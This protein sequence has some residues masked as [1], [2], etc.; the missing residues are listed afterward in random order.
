MNRM[1]RV[2]IGLIAV[3]LLLLFFGGV[4]VRLYTDWVWF[5]EDVGYLPVFLRV[6]GLKWSLFLLFGGSFILFA[7]VNLWLA[8][9]VVRAAE[10]PDFELRG[11]RIVR[12]TRVVQVGTFLIYLLAILVVGVLYG[13]NAS[14]YWNEFL[15]FRNGTP[16]KE[17]DPIFGKDL[18]F[19]LFQLP[20]LSF[21]SGALLFGL[22]VVLG[23]I[24]FFYYFN[25]ALGWLGGMPTFLPSV[26]PHLLILGFLF[27]LSIAWNVWLSRYEVLFSD[28]EQFYGAGYTDLNARL[29]LIYIVVVGLLGVAL[30]CLLN[31]RTGASFLLPV[32]GFAIV[33]G[34]WVLASI[35]YPPAIQRFVVV[36]N[37]LEREMPYLRHHLKFTRQ[38]YGLDRFFTKEMQVREELTRADL[39]IAPRTLANLR[40]WDYR[41]LKQV[42]NSL[43]AL[44]PYYKFVDID[45]DRYRFGSERRQVLLALRE[46]DVEGLPPQAQ[47]WQNLHLLYTHG[48]GLVMNRVN[49]ATPEGQPLF[50]I[51]DLPPQTS[52]GIALTNP[53]IYFGENAYRHV[54][55]RSK[56]KELD[57][58]LL[59]GNGQEENRYTIYEA[60]GGVA[61]DSFFNRFMF[62]LRL[63]DT[64]LLLSRDL[65]PR[66]RLLFRRHIRERAEALFAPYLR[67]DEDPYPVIVNGGITWI[68]DAYTH[69]SHYP[70]SKPFESGEFR[71]KLF[72]YLRNS[73]KITIDAYTGDVKA[74][75]VD[76][77]DPLIQVYRRVFPRLFRPFAEM[78]PEL[79]EHIR[80]PQS[81]FTVQAAMLQLYHMKDPRVFFNKEDAW[82]IARELFAGTTP[83]PVE[84]YYVMMQLPGER[85]ASFL[86]ILPFTPL[87]RDNMVAWLA[88][89]CDPERYGKVV[90]YRF[91]KERLVYGPVQ[92]EARISQNPEIAQQLN[93]WNQQGSE[94]IRGHLLVIPIGQSIL[95]LEPIY[96]KAAYEAAIP[97]L[98][99]VIVG[100]GTAVVMADTVAEGLAQL[101]GTQLPAPKPATSPTPPPSRAPAAPAD[102]KSLIEGANRAYEDAQDALKRGDWATYGARMK[103]VETLLKRLREQIR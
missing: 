59:I 7:L 19:Y 26:K 84:P 100:S 71:R 56:H 18:G 48:Y 65:T 78:P 92:V 5:K 58:P 91:P 85:E 50:T 40:L 4:L 32:G 29:P 102:L 44:K 14:N 21:V 69:S 74:Y 90:L 11:R 97:E 54:I 88:A 43:Q 30:S 103:E 24:T 66:S 101:I 6:L 37:Q 80:Y 81:L 36:P 45:V 1:Q 12:V 77:T 2:W 83:Q 68:W 22:L 96:L 64:N 55:V 16:V 25:R 99:K 46:L 8:N 79:R 67:L 61:L 41:P 39:E 52:S 27:L 62:A 49:E 42:Y 20:F 94:V 73:V 75:V 13:L 47:R 63:Q 70:Y 76:E 33:L 51:K 95:Y 9:R 87:G 10:V 3:A 98:K 34:F 15:L 60:E 72:N 31:L 93:L 28:H 82:V 17:A 35:L 53:A 86:L 89:H 38:A 23:G 57:Y